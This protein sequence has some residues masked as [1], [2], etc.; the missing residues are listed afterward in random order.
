MASVPVI[1]AEALNVSD[2]ASEEQQRR[3]RVAAM[4]ISF[5]PV[6]LDPRWFLRRLFQRSKMFR[7]SDHGRSF[8][9]QHSAG[10]IDFTFRVDSKR[11]NGR[12]P[13]NPG[14]DRPP[15]DHSGKCCLVWF[16]YDST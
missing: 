7:T 10:T 16:L 15:S 13:V 8:D 1:F 9:G 12:V 14:A 11:R 2:F 5:R 4:A 3:S 6:V